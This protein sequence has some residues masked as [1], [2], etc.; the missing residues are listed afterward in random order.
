MAEISASDVKTLRE[1]TGA[2][3]MECKKALVDTEGDFAR[4]E[5]LLKE[6][7]L[8]AV[9]K[10]AG[11]ATNEGKI[12]IKIKVSPGNQVS[13]GNQGSGNQGSEAVLVELATETDFVARN[14]EFITLG[15]VIAD[16]ALEKGYTEPN[17]ELNGMVTDL[18]TKIRE[19]MGLKRIKTIKAGPNELL[20]S[21]IHGDGNIGV[22][23]K[24][25]ADKAAALQTEEAKTLAFDLAL[26][27]AAFN[28][29]ALD[30]S[31]VDAGFLKEQE[32]IF[33]KQLEADEK[34]KSKPANV[35]ENILKGK[36]NKYLA[37]ICLMDQGFVKDEKLTV[38]Q[39]LAEGSKKAGAALTVNDFVYFKVG[40]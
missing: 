6:K 36:V 3:M 15:G 8:A 27:I 10:R 5:K 11:R 26:H 17:D 14:P 24:L 29:L 35:L 23:V 20:T 37:D 18:A 25:G 39:A 12:F 4:A 30:K 38:A 13:S 31:K 7:G 28:P 22:V 33:R 16:K 21:Y 34:N 19:N 9:E 40:Q 1:K 32:E 2:G